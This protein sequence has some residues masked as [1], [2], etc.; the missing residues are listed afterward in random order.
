MKIASKFE[1][2]RCET[3]SF[4]VLAKLCR[5][6]L[7]RITSAGHDKVVVEGVQ[8]A[9]HSATAT[10]CADGFLLDVS[11]VVNGR[12]C[13]QMSVMGRDVML[14][15]MNGRWD[16][17]VEALAAEVGVMVTGCQL[18]H[19]MLTADGMVMMRKAT[20]TNLLLLLL[21]RRLLLIH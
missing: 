10:A 14:V 13:G 15:M 19:V 4:T 6:G 1:K 16:G 17:E 12:S 18:S 7:M 3:Y 2:K 9:A 11:L 5:N 21:L 8:I 20:Q